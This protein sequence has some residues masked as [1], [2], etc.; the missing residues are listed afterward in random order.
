MRNLLNDCFSAAQISN[1]VNKFKIQI[2]Q[3]PNAFCV[4]DFENQD[5]F[6][7]YDFGFRVSVLCAALA[8]C[9][10][11]VSGTISPPSSG[12][13]SPFPHGTC[14]LSVFESIQPWEFSPPCFLP[15]LRTGQYSSITTRSMQY[16]SCTGLSP[17]LAG[18]SRAILLNK[19]RYKIYIRL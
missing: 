12:C 10:H 7:I 17:S 4:L 2:F 1:G 19:P 18:L 11:M 13:F 3:I 9:K 5:L 6:R 15:S 14:S 8:P 16:F